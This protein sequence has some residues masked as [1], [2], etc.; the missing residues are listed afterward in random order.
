MVFHIVLAGTPGNA[1]NI[2]SCDKDN[3]PTGEFYTKDEFTDW[4]KKKYAIDFVGLSF[5][6]TVSSFFRI[7]GKDNTDERR[8]LRGVPGQVWRNHKYVAS[9]FCKFKDIEEFKHSVTEQEKRLS[10]F[11]QARK[12][13][14]ISNLVGGM[15]SIMKIWLRLVRLNFNWEH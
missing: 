2:F 9:S 3:N 5:R 13:D 14:F 7:Y 4:L 1:D 11:R 15:K 12:Y 10:A 6:T 8:P